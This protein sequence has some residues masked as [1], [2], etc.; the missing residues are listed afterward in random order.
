M[1]VS[2]PLGRP[3]SAAAKTLDGG[4]L[5]I[6]EIGEGAAAAEAAAPSKE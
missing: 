4:R 2:A 6:E 3:R 5:H 1:A